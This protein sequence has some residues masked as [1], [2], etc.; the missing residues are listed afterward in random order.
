MSRSYNRKDTLSLK[1]QNDFPPAIPIIT[2][3]VTNPL[4]SQLL[5]QSPNPWLSFVAH[6]SWKLRYIM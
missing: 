5:P 4:P 2:S 1:T 3:P 6:I